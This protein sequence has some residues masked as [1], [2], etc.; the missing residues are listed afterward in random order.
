MGSC[1]TASRGRSHRPEAL[2]EQ[3]A[4]ADTALTAVILIDVPDDLIVDR[5]S[6]RFT[7]P[8]GHVYD[9]RSHSG[10]NGVCEHDGEP[11]HRRH[12]DTLDIVRRRL[13]V[14]REQTAPLEDFYAQQRLLLRIDGS[15][16]PDDVFDTVR[17]ALAQPLNAQVRPVPYRK[18]ANLDAA[19][20]RAAALVEL[21]AS[22]EP[23]STFALRPVPATL[24][25]TAT[26]VITRSGPRAGA[27][28]ARPGPVWSFWA[29]APQAVDRHEMRRRSADLLDLCLAGR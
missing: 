6:G 22:A 5:I 9:L 7:C 13:T 17:V 10:R 12:D 26:S 14:Y 21:R 24:A 20:G 19:R 2:G 18:N 8:Q 1:S 28:R 23:A 15:Q 27:S 16:P 3:L 29:S 11:L 4:A 25:L